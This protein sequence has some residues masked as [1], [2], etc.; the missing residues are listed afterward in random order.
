MKKNRLL[1]QQRVKKYAKITKQFKSD[2][3][4]CNEPFYDIHARMKEMFY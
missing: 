1:S 2:L 4:L 3:K